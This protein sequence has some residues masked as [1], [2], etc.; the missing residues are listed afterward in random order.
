MHHLNMEWC[1]LGLNSIL[2]LSFSFPEGQSTLFSVGQ[3]GHLQQK[4]ASKNYQVNQF[5]HIKEKLKPLLTKYRDRKSWVYNWSRLY[6]ET[7]SLQ[8]RYDV[9]EDDEWEEEDFC[10]F[11]IESILKLQKYHDYLFNDNFDKSEW[12][13]ICKLW[14]P[15]ME[16]LFVRSG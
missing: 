14:S 9:E 15:I 1:S 6:R 2:D 13:Y 10:L 11:F 8:S 4:F 12:D 7:K 3:W 16:R 5:D